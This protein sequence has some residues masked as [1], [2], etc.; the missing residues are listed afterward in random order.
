MTTG[1]S[2]AGVMHVTALGGFTWYRQ[3]SIR[4]TVDDRIVHVDPWGVTDP[5]PAD[6]V[7]ITH[8][9]FDHCSPED[10]QRV[11]GATTKVVAPRDVA[12][13]LDGDVI[14]V[15]PGDDLHVA[16]VHVTAVPAYNVVAGREDFHPQ[17][18]RWVGYVL[19][20]GGMT[21]F[22]AGDTDH[23]PEHEALR[24]D[25]A[26]LPIGGTYTMDAEQAGALARAMRPGVAVPMHFGFVVGEPTDAERFR[27]AAA[28]VAVEVL[29]PRHPFGRPD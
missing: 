3:A 19:E 14:A 28:P 12:R 9:H 8:A 7:L 4:W 2:R 26:F 17:R 10:I 5:A 21:W 22:H 15:A 25:A 18:N 6:L 11:R 16:G 29:E 20:A 13:E 27:R 24:V 23:L 1:Y